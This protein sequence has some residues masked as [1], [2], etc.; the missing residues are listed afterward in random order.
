M[1]GDWI[2]S[3]PAILEGK[4]C[5]R[6]TR[7]SVELILE[8]LSSGASQDDIQRAYPHVP[9]AGIAAAIEYAARAL[10]NDVIWDVKLPRDAE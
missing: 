4:P 10:K 1:L 7:I 6:G 5:V 2:A 8:L 3:D 9:A